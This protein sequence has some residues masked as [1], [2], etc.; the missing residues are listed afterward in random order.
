M[1]FLEKDKVSSL[2]ELEDKLSTEES[3]FKDILFVRDE[4][5]LTIYSLKENNFGRPIIPYS[6]V[7]TEDLEFSMWCN[8]VKV[9]HARVKDL[10]ND[11]KVNSLSGVLNIFVRVKNIDEETEK[12]TSSKITIEHCS[13]L[14]EEITPDLDEDTG[15]KIS[16]LTE[17]LNLSIVHKNARRYSSDILCQAVLWDCTSPALYRQIH[18]NGILTIPSP[19]H[20][21][22]LKV[23]FSAES[24]ITESN[25]R[26]LQTR[27]KDLS[28][29]E[30]ITNLI[31]DEVYSSKRV[32]MVNGAIFGYENQNITKTL[33]GFMIKSV[34]GKYMDIACLFPIDKLDSEI[35]NSMW[36]NVLREVTEIGFDV[37][38]N[39]LD[40]H[41][42]N[43]KFYV[44]FLGNGYLRISIPHP[45]KNDGSRI[46]LLYDYVHIF[47]CIY[48]ILINKRRLI[49]PDFDGEKVAPDMAHIEKLR[50][51]ELGKPAKYSYK[52]SD[53]VLHS[54]PIEKTNVKLADSLFHEST[55]EGL[56]FYS[57]HGYP[58][59]E[60][61]ARYLRIVRTWFNVCNVK[62]RYAGQ[63]NR[64]PV[65]EPVANFDDFQDFGALQ[66]LEKFANWIQKWEQ[67][68]KENN[69]FKNGLS[70][71]T[72]MTTQQTS[73]GLI[74]VS[75]C[76]I[77]EKGFSYVLL[78]F[79]NSDPL[80]RRYGWYRQLAGGN[81]YLSVRQFLEAEKKIR[82]QTLV[83]YSKLSFKE[84]SAILMGGQPTED[85]TKEAKDLL[86]LLGFDFEVEFDVKDEQ[87][88]LF[89]IAGFLAFSELKKISCE[90][91]ICL[92]AKSKDAPTI[93]FDNEIGDLEYLKAEFLEQINR[94]GL[95]TPSDSM[96]ICV[97]Y[98]RQLFQKI[99]DKGEI[100]K[101]FL[102]FKNQRNVFTACLEL[103]M[104]YDSNSAAILEQTCQCP[105]PH[106]FSERI[107]SIGD[108]VFNTF[109]KNFISEINDKIHQSKK[110]KDT[111]NDEKANPV[112]KKIK[113]LQSD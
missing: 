44:E 1:E 18:Q 5:K 3:L 13:K 95:C 39:T 85:T 43:R 100:E 65:R 59:F 80:E 68:C 57:K 41:S 8:E 110:R 89:Y 103:K 81:Y 91:C 53:K 58:E 66:Y 22:R 98:A 10:C 111:G 47:K 104:Q 26:Y 42:S 70:R 71:E 60:V 20:V 75:I 99:F 63:R 67:M 97:L 106:K 54:H 109:S 46:Y 93:D 49:C 16:F 15:K 88:I 30:I 45:F 52:L 36:R 102:S 29:R 79:F 113:K 40:G 62:S 35:L 19:K 64:D 48:N 74:G 6:V 31:L 94:G 61:T 78:F 2:K 96:Y 76:L 51:L 86:T 9:P 24:G 90:F 25:K 17:Q 12:E 83:K 27:I 4:K 50:M 32:E 87:A 101:K 112:Q 38:A 72:F 84:A 23:P 33:L 34:G 7:I 73:R 37:A 28:P 107:K 92:F 105:D 69:N 14:L 56:L 108:R 55:I 82:V 21:Q 11:K 77:E